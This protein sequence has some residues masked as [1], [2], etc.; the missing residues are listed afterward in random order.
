MLHDPKTGPPDSELAHELFNSVESDQGY[1]FISD[2]I[3][4]NYIHEYPC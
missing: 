3:E 4:G 1:A 2:G